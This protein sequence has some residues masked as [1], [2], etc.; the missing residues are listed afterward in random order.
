MQRLDPRLEMAGGL[1]TGR[2]N[3]GAVQPLDL[4][5]PDPLSTVNSM[6]SP[7]SPSGVS[8]IHKAALQSG[9][10][11]ESSTDLAPRLAFTDTPEPQG[12]A[13]RAWAGAAS[14][15]EGVDGDVRGSVSYVG[16]S[17]DPGQGL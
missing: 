14:C 10:G 9:C 11:T 5:A 1:R 3:A 4:P 2:A 13:G 15:Q 6:C 17:S 12:S 8:K 7:Q 16:R